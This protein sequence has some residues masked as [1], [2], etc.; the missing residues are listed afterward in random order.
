MPITSRSLGALAAGAGALALLAL[1]ASPAQAATAGPACWTDGD[2][3]AVRC[4]ADQDALLRG[5][6]DATGGPVVADPSGAPAVRATASPA[7]VD[8]TF[9]LVTV[10]DQ[11]GFTGSSMTY[12][13]T[14]SAVCAV[15]H[16][17]ATLGSW[18]DRIDS[19]QGFNGCS[20]ALYRDINFSPSTPIS[21]PFN[22]TSDVGL[23]AR[24]QASSLVAG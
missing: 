1:G 2:T 16:G 8:A 24:H 15:S 3:G 20:I 18:N 10:Y 13:T 7:G 9:L 5:I 17:F 19:F 4:F 21:G 22:S 11:T 14:N 23:S 6:A 12:T